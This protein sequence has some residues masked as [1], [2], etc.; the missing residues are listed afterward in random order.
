[1]ADFDLGAILNSLTP[2]DIE[3]LKKYMDICVQNEAYYTENNNSILGLYDGLKA[4]VS[5]ALAQHHYE[6]GVTSYNAKNY[7]TAITE[8]ELAVLYYNENADS[9]LYL[10][11][12]YKANGDTE[13][14]KDYY[15]DILSRFGNTT[16][17]R[18][19]SQA[20]NGL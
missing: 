9:L 19:A 8:L 10:A 15:N 7:T 2:D 16:Q 1:M 12:A 3:N 6:L 11:N 14:A 5:S 18:Q 4:S 17:A 13:K 20:L